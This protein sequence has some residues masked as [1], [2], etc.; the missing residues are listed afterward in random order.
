MINHS[1]IILE[2]ASTSGKT[3]VMKLLVDQLNAHGINSKGIDDHEILAH[4]F[5]HLDPKESLKEMHTFLQRECVDKN[6][7]VVCDRFHISH[8][9]ITKGSLDDLREIETAMS[10]YNPL[11]VF[12]EIPE[13]KFG[14]RLLSAK[15]HRGEPWEEEL[16]RRG[17]TD[18]EAIAW[19]KTTQPKL[20]HLYQKSALPKVLYDTE[21][22]SFERI[23]HDLFQRITQR[24]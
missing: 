18:E 21:A 10:A 17:K 1:L 6:R 9:V 11:L 20:L 12:L 22:T 7:V 8:L 24:G 16:R 3:T 23:A 15:S 2:G 13:E 19:F 4:I 14:E 5:S